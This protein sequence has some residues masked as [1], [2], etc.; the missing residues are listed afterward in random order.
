ME[1]LWRVKN[2]GIDID[3]FAD[4]A[5]YN[6]YLKRFSENEEQLDQKKLFYAHDERKK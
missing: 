3:S 4:M 2:S 6:Q 5:E 1:D